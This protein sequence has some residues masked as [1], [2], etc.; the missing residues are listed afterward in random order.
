M[1]A[2]RSRRCDHSSIGQ[3]QT[4]KMHWGNEHAAQWDV[5][6][7]LLLKVCPCICSLPWTCK[8]GLRQAYLAFLAQIQSMLLSYTVYL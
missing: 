6:L 5:D 1:L 4:D 3:Q 8:T 7:S 2:G